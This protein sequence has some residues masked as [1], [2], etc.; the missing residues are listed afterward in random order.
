MHGNYLM[1]NGAEII[2]YADITR[3][4]QSFGDNPAA[5]NASMHR[6]FTSYTRT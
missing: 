1:R 2:S 3:T 5:N 6:V 4:S